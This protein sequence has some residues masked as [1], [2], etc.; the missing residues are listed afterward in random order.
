MGSIISLVALI[1]FIY[2]VFE[3][4][5]REE[6]FNDFI[7]ESGT[8]PSAE[9]AISQNPPAI[10]SHNELPS[11]HL[12]G[13]MSHMLNRKFPSYLETIRRAREKI[14]G[15]I[16]R[17]SSVLVVTLKLLPIFIFVPFLAVLVCRVKIK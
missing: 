5:E 16:I 10:H 3:A 9:W 1:V 6:E 4:F 8:Y 11:I 7:E 14:N 15:M 2:V 13:I 17:A 12:K